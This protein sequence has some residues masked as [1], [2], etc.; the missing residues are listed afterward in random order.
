M[1]SQYREGGAGM[2]GNQLN[3][4]IGVIVIIVLVI[5]LLRLL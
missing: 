4:I 1:G 3:L 5:I 2:R